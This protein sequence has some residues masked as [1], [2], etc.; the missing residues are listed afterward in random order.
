[1]RRSMTVW[2]GCYQQICVQLQSCLRTTSNPMPTLKSTAMRGSC[3]STT[4]W[5]WTTTSVLIRCP[6]SVRHLKETQLLGGYQHPMMLVLALLLVLIV[7]RV[8]QANTSMT[9]ASDGARMKTVPDSS[10]APISGAHPLAYT[11]NKVVIRPPGFLCHSKKNIKCFPSSL[12]NV[13]S[14]MGHM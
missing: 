13:I 12:S 6:H 1:M 10:R 2:A 8:R 11:S 7:P 4:I 14:A 5:F 3:K 9:M